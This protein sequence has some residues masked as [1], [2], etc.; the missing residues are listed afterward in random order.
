MSFLQNVINAL[1]F[2]HI[3]FDVN[4]NVQG[5][6]SDGEFPISE[7]HHDPFSDGGRQ[8]L[9]YDGVAV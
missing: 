1:L 9:I 4:G 3:F 6:E 2:D 8:L 5:L 7:K